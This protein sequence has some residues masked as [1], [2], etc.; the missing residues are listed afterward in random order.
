ME[1]FEYKFFFLCVYEN[2]K[3]RKIFE[4]ISLEKKLKEW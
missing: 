2:L 3:D 4:N 1:K